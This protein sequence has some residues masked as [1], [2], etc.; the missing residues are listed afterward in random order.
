MKR[1]VTMWK[2]RARSLETFL[3]IP[4]E[5][6]SQ[7]NNQHPKPEKK[8]I[9]RKIATDKIDLLASESVGHFELAAGAFFFFSGQPFGGKS[10]GCSTNQRQIEAILNKLVLPPSSSS[11]QSISCFL[12]HPQL[13]WTSSKLTRQE[14]R[15]KRM[16][17]TWNKV[18]PYCESLKNGKSFDPILNFKFK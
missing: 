14:G 12:V 1:S 13:S 3:D 2:T 16:L 15:G 18:S 8:K 17:L 4:T 10:G 6:H 7:S 9:R 11:L 5:G